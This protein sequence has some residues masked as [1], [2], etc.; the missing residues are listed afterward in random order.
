MLRACG[1]ALSVSFLLTVGAIVGGGSPL[2]HAADSG[3]LQQRIGA[4][5]NRISGLK[6]AV[7]AASGRVSNLNAGIGGLERQIAAIQADLDAKRTEL[8][9]LRGELGA[10]RTRLAQLERY[11]AHAQ[12]VLSRQLVNSYESARPD[13]VSVVLESR[14]F[15]DLLER[16]AFAQQIRNQD[17]RIVGQVRAARRTVAAQA[18]RLGGLEKRQQALTVQVLDERNR[19]ALTR[20]GLVRR[21]IVATR[22]RDAKASQ[23]IAA[24]SQVT[25]LQRELAKVQAAQ[26]AAQAHAVSAPAVPQRANGSPGSLP[27]VSPGGGFTF[28]IPKASASPPSTWS[29]DDGVDIS[30]PGGTPEIAVCTGTVV[31]HGIGG[32]GPSAPILHCDAPLGGYDY[33]YYGHAGPGNWVAVGSRLNASQVISEVGSGIV[34]I[35]TGPHLEIGFADSSGSPVGPSSASQ[36]MSLLQSAYGG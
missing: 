4:A 14:G 3:Q 26:A 22:A 31:L 16:L 33:V 18:T 34:G 25:G 12:E 24:R 30:A 19:L 8:L 36:M 10:A 20:I 28:P 2:A 7:G 27:G 29:L 21:Q 35:S 17:V 13:I 5:Q 1:V 23:L 6:S 11:A 32:F 9:K 15:N